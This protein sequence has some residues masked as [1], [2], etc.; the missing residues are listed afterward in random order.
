MVEWLPERAVLL[1]IGAWSVR[2]YGVLYVAAYLAGWW[3]AQRLQRERD[4]AL[5]REQ[6]LEITAWVAIGVL[7]GGRL[8]YALFYEPAYFVAHPSE[9]VALWQGGM[10]VHGGLIGVALVVGWLA[11]SRRVG[12][13]HLADVVVVPGAIGLMLGRLGNIIN[14]EIYITPAMQFLAL[15]QPLILA[16]GAYA[17]LRW[18]RHAGS[19]AAFFLLAEGSSRFFLEWGRADVMPGLVTALTRGQELAVVAM[20][21]GLVLAIYLAR[22]QAKL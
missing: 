20:L 14:E 3:L 16:A 10:S 21:T 9:M 11:R 13:L 12:V 22:R 17:V 15:L 19:V 8:G 5:T 4:L 1:Q 6:W 18:S 7:V 2:W